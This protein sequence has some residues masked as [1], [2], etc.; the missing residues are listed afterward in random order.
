MGLNSK[1]TTCPVLITWFRIQIYTYL[2][3]FCNKN[4]EFKLKLLSSIK[5][6][7]NLLPPFR[8]ILKCGHKCVF[9]FACVD[10]SRIQLFLTFLWCVSHIVENENASSV[11]VLNHKIEGSILLIYILADIIS[12]NMTCRTCASHM[13]CHF[14]RMYLT[15]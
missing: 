4:S 8:H 15:V 12:H 13:I 3:N 10:T 5:C 14:G 9:L 11:H 1:I 7:N 6:I 2:V